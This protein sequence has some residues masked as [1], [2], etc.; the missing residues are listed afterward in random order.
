[1][2]CSRRYSRQNGADVE[3]GLVGMLEHW[4]RIAWDLQDA[5]HATRQRR[6]EETM[7]TARMR[8]TFFPGPLSAALQ[9]RRVGCVP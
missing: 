5:S 2:A 3:R 1:M 6:L 7:Q 9:V 4:Y 8:L